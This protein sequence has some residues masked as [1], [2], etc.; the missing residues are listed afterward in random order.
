MVAISQFCVESTAGYA[1]FAKLAAV[2]AKLLG[3]MFSV[4]TISMGD[5]PLL[6]G[7]RTEQIETSIVG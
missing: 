3:R 5:S 4:A 6:L 2:V 7:P 1:N